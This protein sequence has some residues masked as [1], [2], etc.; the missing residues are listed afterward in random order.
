MAKLTG[1]FD[2]NAVLRLLLGDIPK[3][4]AAVKKLLEQAAGQFAIADTAIIEL[5]FVL[6]RYYGFTRLQI[7]EALG[8][9]DEPKRNKL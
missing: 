7:S 3:Q 2:T 9:T 5:V 6:D 1:S 4:R 8:G